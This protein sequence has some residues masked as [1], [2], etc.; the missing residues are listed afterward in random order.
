MNK[1]ERLLLQIPWDEE[2]IFL[3]RPN[4]FL[5]IVEMAKRNGTEKVM[6]HVHDPGRLPDLLQ[7]GK[8]VHLKY[9]ASDKRKTDWDLIAVQNH[10]RWV[11]VHS[12]YHRKICEELF[13]KEISPFGEIRKVAPEVKLGKSRIDFLL[14]VGN[15]DEIWVEVKGCTLASGKVATFPDAPTL[16]GARHVEEL[17]SIRQKGVRA[18]MFFLI[19]RTEVSCFLPNSA[20]DSHF[21]EVFQRAVEKRVEVKFPVLQ[22]VD[23]SVYYL[24]EISLC[25]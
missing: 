16:R 17:I 1:K 9:S 13:K 23:G 2:A 8:R 6:V 5:G 25:S 19:F 20:V 11:L 3:E 14:E 7:P 18:A 24:K 22:Y 15:G 10:D 4:R 21:A 12:G